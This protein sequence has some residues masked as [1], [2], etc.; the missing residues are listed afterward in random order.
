MDGYPEETARRYDHG[1]GE[2][3]MEIEPL[4][5]VL[6]RAVTRLEKEL[7]MLTARIAPVLRMEEPRP[8]AA[9]LAAVQPHSSEVAQYVYELHKLADRV[10]YIA[11]RVEL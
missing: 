7:E 9:Q 3:K 5:E 2:A 8:D 4:R 1:A 6:A 11:H 10:G